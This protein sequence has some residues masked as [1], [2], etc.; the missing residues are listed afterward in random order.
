MRDNSVI[1]E[2]I[3]ANLT[4]P[5]SWITVYHSVYLWNTCFWLWL[6]CFVLGWGF[7]FAF[8]FAFFL[9][10]VV[11]RDSA[12]LGSAPLGAF[13]C[14]NETAGS[15][16]RSDGKSLCKVFCIITY[17]SQNSHP[18]ILWVTKH[19]QLPHYCPPKSGP[20]NDKRRGR[21]RGRR[22]RRG[23][24]RRRIVL[25]RKKTWLLLPVYT[26]CLSWEIWPMV[27]DCVSPR[28][29]P[30]HHSI[31]R[32]WHGVVHHDPGRRRA[33]GRVRRVIFPHYIWLKRQF[34]STV[35]KHGNF[36]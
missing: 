1:R 35:L 14:R 23:R 16:I 13:L 3:T 11:C 17:Q 36:F 25:I 34:E 30:V 28:V 8:F 31:L 12:R 21:G 15:I 6:Y 18:Q 24:R 26:Q 27:G 33:R 5:S 19:Q 2:E 32:R 22:E 29:S 20:A 7:F 9:R 10:C 4:P